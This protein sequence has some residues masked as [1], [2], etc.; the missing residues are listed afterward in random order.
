MLEVV[1]ALTLAQWVLISAFIGAILT[2]VGGAVTA[3]STALAL[4]LGLI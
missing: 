4:A 1:I 3:V 2:G